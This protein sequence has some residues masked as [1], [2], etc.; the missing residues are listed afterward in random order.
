M[1][2][3]Y[4]DL[5]LHSN[6]SDGKLSPT[7]LMNFCAKEGLKVVALTDHDNINGVKEA[8]KR[9]AELGITVLPGVELS[10]MYNQEEVHIL[11]YNIPYDNPEFCQKLKDLQNIRRTRNILIVKKLM[12]HGI[13]VDA[14]EFLADND[15]EVKGRYHIAKMLAEQG[16]VRT[17]AEAFD[18]YIGNGQPCF[19]QQDRISAFEGVDFLSSFGVIPVL[20][21]PHSFHREGIMDEFLLQLIDRGLMG[22]E[23][24]YRSYGTSERNDLLTYALR[25]NLIA[26]GGSDFHDE[27]HGGI[28]GSANVKLDEKARKVLKITL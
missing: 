24:H 26:T 17:P 25:Y 3:N 10:T 21:H 2:D 1:N 6:C 20:A 15:N 4:F 19:V 13:K 18:K 11:G 9:G 7:E 28:P 16:F 12:A 14:S 27:G 8:Q 23:V 22:I 5:H